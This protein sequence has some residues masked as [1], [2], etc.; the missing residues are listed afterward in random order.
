MA[1][2]ENDDIDQM[3]DDGSPIPRKASTNS[4]STESKSSSGCNSLLN[5]GGTPLKFKFS[6]IL[7]NLVVES[8]TIKR[9]FI[10]VK[11]VYQ[12]LGG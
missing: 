2:S 9:S 7:S 6:N 11:K 12:T 4:D 8:E 3:F 1:S 10:G 5:S